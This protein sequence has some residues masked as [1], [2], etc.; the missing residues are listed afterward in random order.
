MSHRESSLS[1]PSVSRPI[2]HGY[3]EATT[4]RT[5]LVMYA[6][7]NSH[8]LLHHRDCRRHLDRASRGASLRCH[9]Q[10]QQLAPTLLLHHHRP[11]HRPHHGRAAAPSGVGAAP[12]VV[13]DYPDDRHHH[14]ATMTYSPPA[15]AQLDP[16]RPSSSPTRPPEAALP[17]HLPFQ[18]RRHALE[19]TPS[20]PVEARWKRLT[21]PALRQRALR[22][23]SRSRRDICRDPFRA[24]SSDHLPRRRAALRCPEPRAGERRIWRPS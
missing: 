14:A 23:D 11:H 1:P 18:Q 4:V 9:H 8:S 12:T 5:L 7:A 6:H 22:L 3:D 10:P 21:P 17:H 15:Q 20:P 16:G 24:L 13:V 19:R 2:V